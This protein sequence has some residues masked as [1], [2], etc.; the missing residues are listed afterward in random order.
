MGSGCSIRI[1]DIW[2]LVV[3]MSIGAALGLWVAALIA[4]LPLALPLIGAQLGIVIG[5]Y[6]SS[7][8]GFASIASGVSAI[9]VPTT[10]MLMVGS[11]RPP[12]GEH[13]VGS[14]APAWGGV[15]IVSFPVLPALI[16]GVLAAITGIV[17]G[18]VWWRSRE[19][20]PLIGAFG[21]VLCV[22]GPVAWLATLRYLGAPAG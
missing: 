3:G 12:V 10:W 17:A 21:I 22:G 5:V 11:G 16:W 19:G 1:K 4:A 9:A 15:S 7:H 14:G 20:D 6:A 18:I 13:A 8:M 2:W